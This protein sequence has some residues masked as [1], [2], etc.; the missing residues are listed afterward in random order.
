MPSMHELPLF[1]E[2]LAKNDSWPSYIGQM[3]DAEFIWV[4]K[5]KASLGLPTDL[6]PYFATAL[7]LWETA[8]V[9][10]ANR[11]QH[12]AAFSLRSI[13]E[14]VALLWAAH[15]NVSLNT[16]QLVADFESDNYPIRK[17]A[18]DTIFDAARKQDQM[19]KELYDM[20]SRYYGHISHLDRVPVKY[21]DPKDRLLAAR[22]VTT[23]LF[24]LFD[25]GHC[26]LNLVSKLLT[27][28]GKTPP[29][30]VSGRSQKVNPY[31]FMRVASHVMCEKHSV[32]KPVK[33]GV[34][35][36]NI[37]GISG[38]VGITNIYRGGMEVYRYRADGEKP[39]L[40]PSHEQM[41][42]FALFA[43]GYQDK[44]AIKVKLEGKY[45][46]GEKF[47]VSWDKS[48]EID[49]SCLAN[50]ASQ[51]ISDTYPFFDYISAFIKAI[52]DHEKVKATKAKSP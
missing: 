23:P 44:D 2:D 17:A 37:A 12:F 32:G 28:Q 45:P 33:L 7:R 16:T 27:V 1:A 36:N 49:G 39:A 6:E 35:Y 50:I 43:V 18:S 15:P 34:L 48:F 42:E 46:K 13:L 21:D 5:N 11:A 9:V 3:I 22:S 51:N 19:L 41:A 47:L 8:I 29:P 52:K 10:S 31:R 20:L 25:V 14:R 30:V 40:V 26:V 38:S 4:A 24:L